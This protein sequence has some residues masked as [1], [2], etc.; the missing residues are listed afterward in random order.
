MIPSVQVGIGTILHEKSIFSATDRCQHHKDGRERGRSA[1]L[2][3]P[4][5]LFLL[6]V[7]NL[8]FKLLLYFYFTNLNRGL[9]VGVVGDISHNRLGMRAKG[10]LK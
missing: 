3:C 2:T 5:P 1:E 9:D 4:L 10:S 8:F 7:P 6:C